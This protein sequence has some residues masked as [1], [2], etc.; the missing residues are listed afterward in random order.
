MKAKLLVAGLL[1]L[2]T[3]AV[4]ETGI[5]AKASTL[6]LGVELNQSFNEYVGVRLG[7]NNYSYAYDTTEDGIEYNFDLE[8]NSVM[9]LLDYHPFGGNFR[10]SAGIVKNNNEFQGNAASQNSYTV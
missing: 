2:P 5:T 7:L 4:A 3:L 6:G 9:L 1:L 10:L 8:L